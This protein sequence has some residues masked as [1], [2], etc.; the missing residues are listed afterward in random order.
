MPG[1]HIL[2]SLLA[3][4][5]GDVPVLIDAKRGDTPQ[6]MRAYARSIFEDLDADA[7]TVAPFCTLSVPLPSRPGIGSRRW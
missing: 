1:Q 7:V 3:S 5:P 2:R 6:T 4:L